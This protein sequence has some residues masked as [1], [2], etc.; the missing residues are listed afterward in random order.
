LP[1]EVAPGRIV[2][3]LASHPTPP[4][5]DGAEDRNGR[6]NHDEIRF[7]A[8]YIDNSPWTYA[9]PTSAGEPPPFGGLD[10][11]ERFVIVGDQN[12]DPVKGD[13]FNHAINQLLQHPR[14]NATFVPASPGGGIDT[15]DFAGGRLRADYVLPSRTGLGVAG[16][17]VFWPLPSQSGAALLAASDHRLVW[18]DVEV[19]PLI[20]EA[21]RDLSVAIVGDD[22][23]L[24]W[25]TAPG[26]AYQVARSTDLA[27]W[28][29]ALSISVVV[30]ELQQ[31]AS[32]VDAAGAVE[33][34][35]FYR[36]VA[37]FEAP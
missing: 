13:S 24:E 2:H 33:S 11:S 20:E 26:V 34:A 7:W 14:V 27:N 1:I 22:V 36:V 35:R 3:L 15:A 19:T 29:T 9:D 21:V 4:V 6:R 23:T 31:T 5:F 25:R 32:A 16:G 28:A 8:G 12:A 30:D 18:L 10:S 17:G 37:A